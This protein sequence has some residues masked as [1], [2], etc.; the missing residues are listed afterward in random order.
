MK[1][2]GTA[3][4]LAVVAENRLLQPRHGAGSGSANGAGGSGTD[5]RRQNSRSL[6]TRRSGGL[7]AI[8]AAL[9]APID[10]P[11]IQSGATP[12]AAKASNAPAW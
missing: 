5:T 12:A 1:K 6:D 7:P 4:T 8:I 9:I 3:N 11:A 2:P 10:T